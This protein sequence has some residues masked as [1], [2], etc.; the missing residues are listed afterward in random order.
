[1][2]I[3]FA[4][5]PGQRRFRKD[6]SSPFHNLSPNGSGSYYDGA[7]VVF[8]AAKPE[9]FDSVKKI[10]LPQ[11]QKLIKSNEAPVILLANK[12]DGDV[13]RSS[14]EV[15]DD[16]FTNLNIDSVVKLFETSAENDDDVTMAFET[17]IDHC[18]AVSLGSS[19]SFRFEAGL[20]IGDENQRFDQAEDFDDGDNSPL[21]NSF[22]PEAP[23]RVDPLE[24]AAAK[25]MAVLKAKA[26]KGTP[27][28][29]K[30]PGEFTFSPRLVSKPQESNAKSSDQRRRQRT[31]RQ[32]A[33]MTPKHR[34]H[35]V[36]LV[37]GDAHPGQDVRT[38]PVSSSSSSQSSSSSPSSTSL[39]PG[40]SPRKSKTKEMPI[41]EA[42]EQNLITGAQYQ[43]LLFRN[44]PTVLVREIAETSSNALTALKSRMKNKRIPGDNPASVSR[45][46][47]SSTVHASGPAS[48]RPEIVNG[49]DVSIEDAFERGLIS[50]REYEQRLNGN[51]ATVRVSE[52]AWLEADKKWTQLEQQKEAKKKRSPAESHDAQAQPSGPDVSI[53]DAFVR[54]LITAKEY[55]SHL[56]S[57]TVTVRVSEEEWREA[58]KK[59]QEAQTLK[60]EE[61]ESPEKLQNAPSPIAT[62]GIDVSI[63]NAWER[64]LITTKEYDSY[65]EQGVATIQVPEEEWRQS[66]NQ[67]LRKEHGLQPD[68]VVESPQQETARETAPERPDTRF[69]AMK[70]VLLNPA[71]IENRIA[72]LESKKEYAVNSED[73]GLASSLKKELTSLRGIQLETRRN[74]EV[75]LSLA[76][77]TPHPPN[78]AMST[79][80]QGRLF[81][82]AR[83]IVGTPSRP[84]F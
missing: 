74:D 48:P 10:W 72:T 21:R 40:G 70:S 83:R 82:P 6:S 64:A 23:P 19:R 12:T 1:M 49:R 84:E 22:R 53:E 76:T 68:E 75:Q 56:D 14:S 28:A 66:H 18:L 80:Q 59:M 5:T 51:E 55:K 57:G 33:R 38:E 37:S 8:D 46:E 32:Q 60:S 29:T 54:K 20:D 9:T 31:R 71:R 36:V 27:E 7:V 30:E 26:L 62:K 13:P 61:E 17:L 34:K 79:Q 78:A 44:K 16:R 2:R 73:F 35:R 39:T 50:G 3:N 24:W 41:E 4:D 77:T 63:E 69:R 25:K 45:G 67:G 11:V 81:S 52:T 65:L 42:Y 47:T 43:R 15:T 58:E